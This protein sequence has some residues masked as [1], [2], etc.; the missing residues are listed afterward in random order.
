[1]AY[2]VLWE[3]H[4]LHTLNVVGYRMVKGRITRY[5]S[6]E[7]FPVRLLTL[8]SIRGHDVLLNTAHDLLDSMV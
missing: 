7:G 1:M 5:L 6:M 3:L 4:I 8:R 2:P